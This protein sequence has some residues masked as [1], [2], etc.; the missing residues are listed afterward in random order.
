MMPE[1]APVHICMETPVFSGCM[2]AVGRNRDVRTFGLASKV[3][4]REF[5]KMQILL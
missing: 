4:A 2:T 3:L 5:Q 1:W